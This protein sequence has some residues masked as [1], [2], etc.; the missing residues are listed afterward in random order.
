MG[1]DVK[2]S[3][4]DDVGLYLREFDRLRS[5]AL[6]GDH[7]HALL[8]RIADDMRREEPLERL[9]GQVHARYIAGT[10]QVDRTAGEPERYLRAHSHAG[11]LLGPR[12]RGCVGLRAG[13]ASRA[14]SCCSFAARELRD[15]TG[16]PVKDCA[17]RSAAVR[18][19]SGP[20][21]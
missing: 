13:R 5:A 20:G 12:G 7:A 3:E 16:G 18:A 15:G 1:E 8:D 21:G 10:R 6:F 17:A 2:L 11:H 14:A 9:T 19:R 4:P